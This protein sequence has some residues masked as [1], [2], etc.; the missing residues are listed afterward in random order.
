MDETQRQTLLGAIAI[1]SGAVG[2]GSVTPQ[3]RA[4]AF[5]NLEQFKA[6]PGRVAACVEMIGGSV[7]Q[8][9]GASG[10]PVDVTVPS[11]LYALGIIQDFLK[12]GYSGLSEADRGQLRASIL[13]AARQLAAPVDGAQAAKMSD[14]TRILAVKIASL[15]ADL[16][17]REFPQRWQTFVSDLFSPVSRG[18]IWCE[19]GADAGAST[20]GVKICLE[21]FKLITEDCTDSDYNARIS[22]TRRND[23][24]LGMNEMSK[25]ILPPLFELLSKQYGDVNNAKST[26]V[27]MKQYLASNGRTVAQMAP[28]EQ[29]QYQLQVDRRDAAGGIVADVLGTLEKFCQSMPID[30]MFKVEDGIDFVAALL[31]L[32]QEDTANSQ[33][34]SV[35]CLYQLSMRKLDQHQWLRLIQ[36]IPPALYEANNAAAQRASERGVDPNSVDMLVEQLDF[37]RSLSK[38]GSTLISAHL[39]NITSDKEISSGVGPKFEAVSTYLRLL[40]E[41]M[42][43]PSGVICGEQINTWVG[44]L[45]DPAI[46]RTTVLSPHLERVLTAYMNHIVQVRWE[47]V[48]EQDH[49]YASLIEA[50][51]DDDDEYNDWLGNVRSKSSQLF[52]SIGSSEPEIAAK[53]VH[54]KIRTLLNAHC[55]G[56][57]RDQMNPENNELTA[58]STACL[59]F[60]GASQPLDNIL[61]GLPSW[62]LDN[63]SY[64]QKRTTIRANIRPLL[65]EIANMIVS[66]SPNDTWLKFRRTTLLEALKHYWKHDPTTLPT[67]VDGLLVYLSATDNPPKAR[68]SEDVVGLRKKAGV[69]LVA[70]SKV[71]PNLLVPWLS[72]LSDRA[73]GLL[74]SGGLS[75]INEMHLYEFLSCVATAVENPVDRANFVAD[76]LSNS[77]RSLEAPEIQTSIQSVEGLLSFTG[78]TQAATN[79]GCVTDHDFVKK[80]TK[81]FSSLFSSLNQLLSVGKRCHE[82]AKKRPNGGLPVQAL[83]PTVDENASNFPDEGSVGINDLAIN[84]PF[85]PLWPKLLPTL[86][87]VLDV[88]LQVWHPE[89]Q[90]SLLR[91]SIQRYAIAVSDEELYLAAKKESSGV[92]GVFGKGGT[93]G[94][95]VSGVDRR[96]MN[97][98]PR[99]A[100]WFNELRNNCFQLLGLLCA[101]RVMFAPEIAPLF[102][103]LVS[104][105]TNPEHLRSMENR[106]FTQY[107]KQFVEVMLLTCPITLYQSHLTAILGPV[108]EHLQL[109]FQYSWGPIIGTGG[110]SSDAAKPLQTVNCAEAANQLASVG[111]ESWLV[112]YYARCGVFVGDLDDSVAGE[113]MVDKARVDL[114]RTFSDMLQSVLA[115]KGGWA[116]VLAN[117][118]K[119]EQAKK[120]PYK[121]MS[122]PKSRISDGK[123]PTNADGT[124]RTIAQLHL[125]ARRML[126]IDKLCHFLL[127]EN[128]QV[129]GFLVLTIIQCLEYPDA[130]TCRRCARLVHRVLETVAWVERYT[131]LLGHRL[132]S[133]AVKAIITEPKW[134]VGIEWE[135]INI[136][137]DINCRLVLGQY[138]LP[139][140]QGPGLQQPKDPSNSMRFEQ[141]KVVD[142]PLLGGGILVAPSDFPRRILMEIGMSQN[143]VVELEKKLAEKR[144]AKDQKDILRDVLRVAADKTKGQNGVL[145][146]ADEA[147]SLLHQNA[148][149]PEV[150]ALPEKL[151]T[152]SMLK[153]KQEPKEDEPDGAWHG[154]IF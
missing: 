26:L 61:H 2:V 17:L 51:W 102:P 85:V 152:Y 31:H 110:L 125:D 12:T 112:A 93:A 37:H 39:A 47:D 77:I 29:A 35:G 119:D 57:P 86:L 71:V 40:S 21:C 59:Q 42:S 33:V 137:R 131:E 101:Q 68:L 4:D 64:D 27:A 133:I 84:D 60:E 109:R 122:G 50:S 91:N 108:F 130:Y 113:A 153:K 90:A 46:V 25:Q 154:G 120:D 14:S 121:L 56:E 65:S 79:P 8:I 11:K 146:R 103:R 16:A 136:I 118:A 124:K 63:G 41:M 106:H 139:G 92:G 24:L 134:M 147:E 132:F 45:R 89:C 116:L 66:W 83:S 75:P 73:K 69:S 129:A 97:L 10:A 126:R 94:S 123:G 99:W 20:A 62:A 52:R 70:V 22:T 5:A 53:A 148:R 32:L 18:G 1:S 115:L 145:E 88:T 95:I 135:L 81:D 44:L 7:L 48:W 82:A 141:T 151:V 34:L 98:A 78:I 96:Q 6:Y 3:Q 128:E 67:G 38:M 107:L 104:I 54:S 138:L 144:S 149:K 74:T 105:I 111:A 28:D 30:W 140:G 15:L 49:P 150:A 58:K 13:T 127:L 80:V 76:V 36:A 114:T 117:K 143:D 100:G 55:N 23:I 19:A 72:Q 87:Q 43:H 142:K 9:A